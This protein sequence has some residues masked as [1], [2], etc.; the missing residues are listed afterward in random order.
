MYLWR[1]LPTEARRVTLRKKTT[2]TWQLSDM[3]FFVRSKKIGCK[4]WKGKNSEGREKHFQHLIVAC[5]AEHPVNLNN[6]MGHEL[7]V[8]PLSLAELNGQ[9]RTGSKTSCWKFDHWH[10]LSHPSWRCRPSAWDAFSHWWPSSG[11]CNWKA[12][13]SKDFWKPC[14]P[15]CRNGFTRLSKHPL[16][17]CSLWTL[18]CA[19][20]Q[21]WHTEMAG[22]RIS[23]NHETCRE[24]RRTSSCKVGTLHCSQR[25]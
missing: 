6:L 25:K 17:W 3:C 2:T 19:V 18:L 7:F 11:L 13:G 1:V 15:L 22:E 14:R 10:F 8:V 23:V 24:Q 21:K 9:L 4:N 20:H 16:H 12:T 5:E